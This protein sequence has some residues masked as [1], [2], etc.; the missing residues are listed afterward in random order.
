MIRL[1]PRKIILQS[2]LALGD[3]VML[4][5]A[6]RDLH[7]LCPGQ[8][9]TDVRTAFPEVWTH[10]PYLT[11]LDAF[12]RTVETLAC[13]TMFVAQS[14]RSPCHY[15]YAFLDFLNRRLKL[16]LQPTEFAGDI[17]LSEA[18]RAAPS[19]IREL[20]GKDTPYWVICAGGKYDLT[21][22]WW[23]VERYQQVVD[24]FRGRIQF[25]QVGYAGH[26]HPPLEGAMDLRGR[27][28]LRQLIR[29]VHN[30]EGVVCGVTSLMHLAAAV[31]RPFDRPGL[32]PCVVIAG[33]R[34]SPHWEAYPGHQFLHTV[35]VLDCCATS[36]C[37]KSRTRPLGDGAPDD[38]AE[39]RC[40]AVTNSLPRCMDLITAND[41]IRRI[42]MIMD[43]GLGRYLQPG[44]TQTARRAIR[45][46]GPS[47]FDSLPLNLSSA[48]LA[49]EAYLAR[50]PGPQPRFNGRGIVI[51]G[52]GARYFV[53]AWV[54]LSALRR[55]GCSL[56]IQLWHLGPHEM[57]AEMEELVARF[58]VVCVDA[59]KL[60]RKFPVRSLG[61]WEIKPYSVTFCPFREVLL[62][63]AD[64]VP[65]RDPTFLFDSP[66]YREAGAIFWP[67]F[68]RL[69]KGEPIWRSCDLEM[70]AG[71]E[72]ESGQLLVDKERCWPAV[73]LAL[74]FNE[75][76]DF[77]YQYLHGD[78]DTFRLAFRRTGTR[79]QL[80]PSPPQPFPGGMYQYDFQGR[81]LFQHRTM[82]KWTLMPNNGCF[83]G[84]QGHAEC[85][86][87]IAELRRHWDG[88]MR[89]LRRQSAAAG[90]TR[91][92]LRSEPTLAA[93]M[94]TCSERDRVRQLTLDDLAA[95]DWGDTPIHV[96]VDPEPLGPSPV[97]A[98]ARAGEEKMQR[99]GRQVLHALQ[100]FLDHSADYLLLLEDDLIFNRNLRHNILRWRPVLSGEVTLAGLYN[101]GFH[102]LAYD[103]RGHAVA[104]APESAFGSQAFLIS[105]AA[106]EHTVRAWN[107]STVAP[108]LRLIALSAQLQHPLFYHSPSLVQHRDV[109]S[110]WGGRPHFARDFDSNWRA[111]S[112]G[113]P[114]L[115]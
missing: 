84:F 89:W 58:D 96:L 24:H 16:E 105:R 33:G 101:A 63:D 55:L 111:G 80:V 37:W 107:T 28:T 5:A 92:S 53:N 103:I 34:E 64:N 20:T 69:K 39:K 41:V 6:V 102:E 25:I 10:N 95:T 19:P 93:W 3:V 104:V 21:I 12:D 44:Q 52:G 47:G 70:P 18:D 15:I 74:W 97:V 2:H 40:V 82:S 110:T 61:F 32:R 51:S 31:P 85:L 45:A 112:R 113:M 75:H 1:E 106:V 73:R 50:S 59:S 62:L 38:R 56:P 49:L 4:T 78:K 108:D 99:I 86:S 71:P 42:E 68:G 100:Q 60:R 57:D 7:R 94:I 65:A 109:P 35:G 98:R 29:L 13:D 87:A 77:Y 115:H 91:R 46:A 72:F 30:C 36:G 48:R 23:A 26:F 17:H 22:K 14:E 114:P 54:C 79:Y 66:E 81:L 8:F 9:V 67:D 76:S 27:T 90:R 43:G 11:G 83:P 88:R